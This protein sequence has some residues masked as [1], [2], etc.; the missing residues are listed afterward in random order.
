MSITGNFKKRFN[1]LFDGL[2]LP[3]FDANDGSGTTFLQWLF[4]SSKMK[5]EVKTDGFTYVKDSANKGT[6]RLQLE[7]VKA[8][9]D[10]VNGV[11]TIP[12]SDS[13]TFGNGTVD[14]PFSIRGWINTTNIANNYI[15]SKSSSSSNREY[16]LW[17]DVSGKLRLTLYD[18]TSANT[19]SGKST[20]EIPTG[21]DLFFV[22]SYDGT[23]LS[24]GI[25]IGFHV[26]GVSTAGATVLAS[27]GTYVAMEG[28]SE[29]QQLG[30]DGTSF[31]EGDMWD[32]RFDNVELSQAQIDLL[33][34]NPNTI[35]GTEVGKWNLDEGAG[36]TAFDS[37]DEANRLPHYESDFSSGTDGFQPTNATLS[38]EENALKIV[39]TGGNTFHRAER[40]TG[41]L[42]DQ[43]FN[44]V[45]DVFIPSDS[46]LQEG[47]YLWMGGYHYQA[48]PKGVWTTLT[49]DNVSHTTTGKYMYFIAGNI[50]G[51]VLDDD[52]GYFLI[53]NIVVTNAV[54]EGKHGVISGG[55]TW[56]TQDVVSF[57]NYEGYNQ[58]GYF[59][60]TSYVT[61]GT[62]DVLAIGE[63][64]NIVMFYTGNTD[65]AVKLGGANDYIRMTSAGRV[66][67]RSGTTTE[68]TSPYNNTNSWVRLSVERENSTNYIFRLY[69]LSDTLINEDL[70]NTIATPFAVDLIGSALGAAKV[71]VIKSVELT[72]Q[73]KWTH[74]GGWLDEVGSDDGVITGTIPE[75]KIPAQT[76]TLD[77]FGVALTYSG[78]APKDGRLVESHCGT[79]D[80]VADYIDTGVAFSPSGDY[81]ISGWF[82]A[83]ATALTS[84]F[85]DGRDANGDGIEVSQVATTSI[86]TFIHNSTS[87]DTISA[88]DDGAWHRIVIGRT[89]TTLS[90][91][92][93]DITGALE[94]TI[95]TDTD[96]TSID[97]TANGIIG[98][99][100]FSTK[101]LF[102][103]GQLANIKAIDADKTVLHY[104]LAEGAGLIAYN[105]ADAT[106]E[107]TPTYESDFSVD[108]DG[109]TALNTTLEGNI[110]SVGGIN[111]V[112]KSS[113]TATATVRSTA[114]SS[115]ITIGRNYK[116]TY[117]VFIPSTNVSVNGFDLE[118]SGATIATHQDLALDAWHSFEDLRV[119]TS[120]SIFLEN[121]AG[122]ANSATIGD[123]IYIKNFKFTPVV[124]VGGNGTIVATEVDFWANTQDLYH[125]NLLEGFSDS[126]LGEVLANMNTAELTTIEQSAL[127][128]FVL[129]EEA[130]NNFDKYD[131]FFAFGLSGSNALRGFKGKVA[132]NN[133]AVLSVEGATFA[134]AEYIDSNF[135]P[136]VDGVNYKTSEGII[137][138]F[139]KTNEQFANGRMF[140]GQEGF[141]VQLREDGNSYSMNGSNLTRAGANEYNANELVIASL[142]PNN[143]E[144]YTNGVQSWFGNRTGMGVPTGHFNVGANTASSG[145]APV[146]FY[147]G[148]L[149]TFIVGGA[150]GFDQVAHASNHL[151]FLIELG[152][153]AQP[154]IDRFTGLSEVQD[155]AIRNFVNQE[156]RDGN[157]GLYDE[158]FCFALGET[159]SLIGFKSK[160]ATNNGATFDVNGATFNGAEYINTNWI[161]SSDGVNYQLDNAFFGSY[162]KTKDSIGKSLTGM[163]GAGTAI[164]RDSEGTS[165]TTIAINSTS[166]SNALHTLVNDSVMIVSRAD[167]SNLKLWRNG[168]T[169]QTIANASTGL[170][171]ISFFTGGNNNAGGL[172][173]GYNGTIST[174]I[175][176]ASIGFDQVA[177]NTNLRAMLTELGT[178]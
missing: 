123:I 72:N 14:Q 99:R 6:N 161:P 47:V 40:Q 60:G 84:I 116:I 41:L 61:V 157:W 22:A 32:L 177:H 44:V 5:T 33:V 10:G 131:E 89:G 127:T 112:L 108:V 25:T 30:L 20:I 37:V 18:L 65:Y 138:T 87:L 118:N 98:A 169:V 146:N 121:R 34:A 71:G 67:V 11:V 173:G 17:I 86:I 125:Y 142:Q 176:G 150:I 36:L 88:Y 81:E 29:S 57:Q 166:N 73:H 43:L 170:S 102:F 178:I 54:E 21:V 97:T 174:W 130:D 64:V 137:G 66:S 153:F 126:A 111:D 147:K 59:D 62:S 105:V 165:A 78:K 167:A 106:E 162:I 63:T 148:I 159:N 68:G 128:N 76:S 141:A 91:A 172:Y 16:L 23:G 35:L 155:T 152:T 164:L 113:A 77:V 154:V 168:G 120:T 95:V 51:F 56:G 94:E 129:A 104:P 134:G 124:E 7:G 28:A 122:A 110:D 158:F 101:A 83:E 92:I 58:A 175:A 93:Y 39:F 53:K 139:I 45:V 132:T 48:V 74:I 85:Y 171:S 160:T 50:G 135:T 69:D 100:S 55:V 143:Q 151:E 103:E 31:F 117:D 144:V 24:S 12:H 107:A 4:S 52:G 13:L 3:S 19:I 115:G 163:L 90:L 79:F 2:S 119:T 46:L 80:G 38:T 42:Q 1:W 133:G 149:S 49:W 96:A 27:S 109:W 140:G 8:I 75:L 15:F 70:I 114:P 156:T 136:S 9:F 145:G 82:K 26:A